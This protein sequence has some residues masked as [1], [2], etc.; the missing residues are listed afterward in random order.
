M[1]GVSITEWYRVQGGFLKHVWR[2]SVGWE[3]WGNLGGCAD[4]A[5]A[6]KPRRIHLPPRTNG[7]PRRDAVGLLQRALRWC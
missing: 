2:G 4:I 6:P 3:M 1:Q 7:V 5:G